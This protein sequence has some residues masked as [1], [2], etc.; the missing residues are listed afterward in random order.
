M[1]RNSSA[2]CRT[3]VGADDQPGPGF[4]KCCGLLKGPRAPG[5][6]FGRRYRARDQQPQRARVA[7][8]T[9]WD[10]PRASLDPILEE[11][12]ADMAD[13]RGGGCAAGPLA[14]IIR[15]RD[16][17]GGGLAGGGVGAAFRLRARR[18]G[19]PV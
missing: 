13:E 7:L 6:T 4:A 11:R 3:A 5:S 9:R 1:S 16:R 10:R 14:A 18:V 19:P 12:G 2:T 15:T 8:R 17:A